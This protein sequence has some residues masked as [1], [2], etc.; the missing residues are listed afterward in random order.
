MKKFLLFSQKNAVLIFQE[1][2]PCKAGKSK[3]FYI[4]FFIFLERPFQTYSQRK[5]IS[6]TFPYKEANFSN[7]KILFYNYHKAFFII[8]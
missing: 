1:T 6:Y 2:E 7:L 3:K 5:K 8:L 4:F